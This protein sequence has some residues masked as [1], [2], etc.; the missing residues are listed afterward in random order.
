M[1]LVALV[2]SS[3]TV[4][5]ADEILVTVPDTIDWTGFYAGGHIGYG[6]GHGRYVDPPDV[7]NFYPDGLIGG[8]QAGYNY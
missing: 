5:A 7:T 4:R 6:W 1:A 2:A 8:V 3:G